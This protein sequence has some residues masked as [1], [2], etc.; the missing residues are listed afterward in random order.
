MNGY[1][2]VTASGKQ[3]MKSYGV[4]GVGTENMTSTLPVPL[5]TNT[6]RDKEQR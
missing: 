1:N 3:S 2:S 6:Y 5:H 4:V